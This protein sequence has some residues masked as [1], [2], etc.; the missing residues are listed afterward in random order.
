MMWYNFHSDSVNII[1]IGIQR[2]TTLSGRLGRTEYAAQPALTIFEGGVTSDF[3]E[4]VFCVY[5]PINTM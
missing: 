3:L 4:R 1:L 2:T 5:S